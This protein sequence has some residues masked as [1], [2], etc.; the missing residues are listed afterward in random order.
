MNGRRYVLLLGVILMVLA[1]CG[2]KGKL[3]LPKE[4][5]PAPKSESVSPDR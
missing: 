3:Y 1:G 2:Q 5:K 4:P